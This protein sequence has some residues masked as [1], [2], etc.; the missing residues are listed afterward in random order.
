[1]ISLGLRYL[2]Q[3]AVA[4]NLARQRAEW[5]PHPGRVFMAMAAA[6]FE[7][8]ADPA[9]RAALEW[10]EAAGAPAMRASDA[11][12]RSTVRAYVPVNDVH[13]GILQR[14]R[15]DR[16]FP[17]ARPHEEYVHLFWK[18]TP[19]AELRSALDRLCGKVTRVGHS[20]SAVQMWVVPDGHESVPNWLPGESYQ[21]TR[22]RVP[23]PGTL[24]SLEHAFNAPAIQEYSQLEEALENATGQERVRLKRKMR[25]KFP[26]GPPEYRRPQLTQWQGY[27]HAV[28]RSGDEAVGEGPFDESFVVL[29]KSEGPMLGIESTLQL[30][31]AL[32]NSVMKAA[33]NVP[34]EWI[35]GHQEDGAPSQYPHL[36]FFPLPYVA[37][38]YADGHILGLGIAIRASSTGE[39]IAARKSCDAFSAD[40]SLIRRR[41]RSGK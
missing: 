38:E 41:A 37:A 32:R 39:T 13:G 7:C 15:Q 23:A 28:E 30:T 2:T 18:G 27:G 26:D 34:P 40:C 8:G 4:T 29:T 12:E 16:A 21:D 9:E 20:S 6:H 5:P 19:A 36:A 24:R 35:S 11:D 3:Y 1:M 31:G 33:G 22:L 25:T 10:L 14:P 17:R